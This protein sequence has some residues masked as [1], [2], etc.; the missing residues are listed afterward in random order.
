[1]MIVN[2]CLDWNIRLGIYALVVISYTECIASKTNT[3]L[4]NKY[5]TNPYYQ[6]INSNDPL[7]GE[8]SNEYMI[9]RKIFVGYDKSSRPVRYDNNTIETNIAM[10]LYHI[11]DTN[12]KFQTLSALVSLRLRWRDD[13]LHWN[14]T[15]FGGTKTIWVKAN[16]IWT[17][18]IFIFNFADDSFD[19]FMNTNAIISSNGHILWM[20][21]AVIKIYCT[22]NVQYFP[23]DHQKCSIVFISWTYSGFELNLIKDKDFK[24]MVY[25][26]SENQEWYVD[27]ISVERHEKFY[28]CCEEP[29]PDVTFTIHMRRRSLFYIVN[30]IFPCVLIYG[31]SFLGFFLPVESG[32][33]VNLEITILLALVVFLLLVGETLPP[34]PDAIPVLGILYGTTMLMVSVALVMAVIVTNIYLRKDSGRKVPR[35]IMRLLVGRARTSLDIK[36]RNENNLRNLENHNDTKLGC[37]SHRADFEVDTLS[38]TSEMDAL[39]C[40]CTCAGRCC[41]EA[42]K[43]KKEPDPRTMYEWE[44]LAKCVDRIFFWVFLLSSITALLAMFCRIPFGP[45]IP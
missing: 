23:F 30:L 35:F 8:R 10:S 9:K 43:M 42:D 45:E 1:M 32:E 24:N 2:M 44:L 41:P 18:D 40:S 19:D 22:L 16:R 21:P 6:P 20:F 37:E 3:H 15:E 14:E 7:R 36:I 12:E 34:T 33:K 25:Y 29:Y 17:P 26:N 31:T 11:L 13:Y 27:R 39:T 38:D 4:K 28:A 5:Q